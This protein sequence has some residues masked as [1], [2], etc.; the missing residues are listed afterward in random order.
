MMSLRILFSAV[1]MWT[2]P[3][4]KGGPSVQ[5]KLSR[6]GARGLDARIKAGGLPLL[7]PGRLARDQ[8]RLH[9]EVGSRQIQCVLVVHAAFQRRR[10]LAVAAG[11][12]NAGQWKDNWFDSEVLLT[13]AA[14][15]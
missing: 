5:D 9:R 1:P 10:K 13:N 11:S 2:L 7:Q 12:V 3:L 4:A 8:V 14:A 15:H 6:T